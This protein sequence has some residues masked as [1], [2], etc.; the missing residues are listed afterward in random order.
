[1]E[2]DSRPGGDRPR[3]RNSL[4]CGLKTRKKKS[5]VGLECFILESPRS[6]KAREHAK[7]LDSPSSRGPVEETRPP[8]KNLA[9]DVE[10]RK[11]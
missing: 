10:G 5:T 11:A 3:A 2:L 1:M 4:S 8:H 7:N 9:G 6:G